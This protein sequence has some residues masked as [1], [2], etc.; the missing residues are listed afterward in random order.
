MALVQV[1]LRA[2]FSSIVSR[3]PGK[4]DT[5]K[6]LEGLG[7]AARAEWISLASDELRSTS[8]DYIQS[9]SQV[10]L[11]EKRASIQLVGVLP[12]MVEQGWPQTDLRETVLTSPKA[13]TAAKGHRYLAV[14]FRH[15]TPGTKGSNVGPAMPKPIHN[16][17]K[18]LAAT[19]TAPGRPGMT[20]KG[21][22]LHA[23][24]PMGRQARQILETK[25]RP[26]HTTSIYTGMI[27]KVA[28]Y[29]ERAGG[30]PVMQASYQTFRTISD[31]VKR[32]SRHWVHPGIKARHLA[33]K[34]QA[35]VG[36]VA[37]KVVSDAM[38]T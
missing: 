29:G 10:A 27:R 18:T 1:D 35:F 32:D 23:G 37:T 38:M 8:R 7:A 30:G 20:V 17:A 4:G 34:V 22:R 2:A 5:R 16:V 3:L 12:N 25:I 21:E 13:K 28:T 19:M 15:G 11:E 24:M 33:E 26:W 9:I 14:P 6:V 36:R 31:A